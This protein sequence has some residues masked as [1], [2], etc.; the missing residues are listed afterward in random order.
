MKQ[1]ISYSF[2]LALELS[3][4]GGAIFQAEDERVR[5]NVIE[6]WVIW[7]NGIR[8]KVC[9]TEEECKSFLEI[10]LYPLHD[11]WL[12]ELPVYLYYVN[13]LQM[14][15]L[16]LFTLILHLILVAI[17]TFCSK[18]RVDLKAKHRSKPLKIRGIGV[19]LH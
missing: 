6:D 17:I 13:I 15:V 9:D 16:I 12:P 2:D 18:M 3:R 5:V 19:M 11:G 4:V 10:A 7:I 1:S 14:N 8:V